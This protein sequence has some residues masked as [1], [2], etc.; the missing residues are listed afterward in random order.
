MKSF[1]ALLL[2]GAWSLTGATSH[3]PYKLSLNQFQ[4]MLHSHAT[5]EY[6]TEAKWQSAL[7]SEWDRLMSRWEPE[8]RNR[9]LGEPKQ[10]WPFIVC[11]VHQ[12]KA[13][14]KCKATIE[15]ALETSELLPVYNKVD[16]TCFAV[17]ACPTRVTP[18]A[19]PLGLVAI[20][21]TPEMKIAKGGISLDQIQRLDVT[22][23]PQQTVKK[24]S[25]DTVAAQLVEELKHSGRRS[26]RAKEFLNARSNRTSHG[27]WTSVLT[28]PC[29]E[30]IESLSIEVSHHSGMTLTLPNGDVNTNGCLSAA[31]IDLATHP[32]VCFVNGYQRIKLRND[33]A[34]GIVQSG[35]TVDRPFHDTGIDGTG[36]VV[37]VSDTGVDLDNCYFFD[38]EN[39]TPK[40]G[41]IYTNARKVIQYVAYADGQEVA[42]GHGTHVAGLLAGH[43]VGSGRGDGVA[44]GA[45]LS[46]FDIGD[47]M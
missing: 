11:D 43:R 35:N 29:Q 45:K 30:T 2:S 5:A 8:P 1:F 20:P 7:K 23:C 40:D 36:Q 25:T 6:T 38:P 9:R 39:P 18:D 3:T 10:K 37:A 13:G 47:G 27:N 21:M 31:M 46:I 24:T 19:L 14:D 15:H 16:M 17:E 34:S 33:A 32:Q 4:N 42:K 41:R 28:E 12:G 44:T 26:L 22:F